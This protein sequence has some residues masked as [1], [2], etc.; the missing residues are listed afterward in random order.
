MAPQCS[1]THIVRAIDPAVDAPAV[2][3]VMMTAQY[4]DEHWRLSYPILSLPE[5]I[6]GL[7]QRLPFNL[8]S[9]RHAKRHQMALDLATG[10]PVGYARWILPAEFTTEGAGKELVWPEAR[11]RD[12]TAEEKARFEKSY[13]EG[14]EGGV[15]RGV[16]M[17]LQTELGWKLEDAENKIMEGPGP[18]L[19]KPF[20]LPLVTS[21]PS[22][23]LTIT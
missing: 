7:K 8:I 17:D 2:A 6:V 1:N 3:T 23:L 10:K 18:W 14:C 20:P 13:G 19:C 16:R 11:T 22:M 4:T 15:S 21:V 9:S 5:I 12:I